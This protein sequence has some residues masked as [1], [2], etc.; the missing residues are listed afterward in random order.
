MGG[1]GAG[2]GQ[3]GRETDGW[4]ELLVEGG[5]VFN[6]DGAGAELGPVAAAVG[7]GADADAFVVAG[8]HGAG[9]EVD[10]GLVGRDAAHELGGRG[11]V[12]A[13]EC[14]LGRRFKVRG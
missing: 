7:A 10:D 14:Q 5:N 2:W 6:V 13:W 9:D 12:A 8:H 4:R 11:L 3:M 1:G